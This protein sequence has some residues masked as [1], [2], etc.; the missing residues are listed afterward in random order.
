MWAERDYKI[1]LQMSYIVPREAPVLI[2]YQALYDKTGY[3]EPQTF[4]IYNNNATT[5]NLNNINHFQ[6]IGLTQS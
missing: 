3:G 1:S 4:F 6:G 5:L 2:L